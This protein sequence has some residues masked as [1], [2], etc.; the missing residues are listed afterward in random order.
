MW[1]LVAAV[2]LGVL[3]R[4]EEVVPGF[5]CGISSNGGWLLVA[6][7]VGAWGTTPGRAAL[8]GCAALTLANASYS[9]VAGLTD[10]AP[11]WFLLGVTGG[12]LFGW[13]GQRLRGGAGWALLPLAV[14]LIEEGID[15]PRTGDRIELALGLGVL[16]LALTL[17][18]GGYTGRTYKTGNRPGKEVDGWP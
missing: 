3:S 2:T 14:V 8:R 16:V 1:F 13:L 17:L 10:R 9:W 5:S 4:V 12:A 7:A 18:C 11:M 6:L 15:R